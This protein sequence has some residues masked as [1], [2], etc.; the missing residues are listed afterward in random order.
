MFG[1]D[2]E[3]QGGWCGWGDVIF[4]KCRNSLGQ[5]LGFGIFRLEVYCNEYGFY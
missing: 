4:L 3:Q 2:N 5:S 1:V